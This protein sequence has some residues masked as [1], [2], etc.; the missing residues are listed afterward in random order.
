MNQFY[1]DNV[2]CKGNRIVYHY[3]V[4]GEWVK[5]FCLDEEFFIEY[6]EPIEET[7]E[8]IA[9]IPLLCNILPIAWI[10]DAEIIVK[11]VDKDFFEHVL[12]IK[13]GY[14]DM[15]PRIDFKGKLIPRRIIDN[16]YTPTKDTATFFSGG[17]DAFSTLI[18]HIEERPTLITINGSD[19][20]L[21]NTTGWEKVHN[22]AIT[23]GTKFDCKNLFITSS[24][25]KFLNEGELTN[26]INS[27]SGENWW[28]GFQHGIGLIGHAAPYAYLH[29][30][31]AV[32]IASSF[33]IREKGIVTCASDPSIDNHVHVAS[34]PTIHDG[35]EFTRQMKIHRICEYKE[36]SGKKIPLRVCWESSGGGNCC[37]C[38]KC[39]RTIMAISVENQDPHEYG[40]VFDNSLYHQIEREINRYIIFDTVFLRRYWMEIQETLRLNITRSNKR[41]VLKWVLDTDFEH[42]D[43][44]A[45]V[46]KKKIFRFIRRLHRK[47]HG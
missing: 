45:S 27:R 28:H 29:K 19:I 10:H 36:K 40:F 32:Y 16:T 44:G 23:S 24:F 18:S 5:Y 30:L 13:Q 37:A 39:Y 14:I 11:E 42:M 3:T 7:P 41:E 25:R 9:V 20:Q 46:Y 35:Y 1:L 12:E 17:V 26:S 8:S 34:C 4:S 15:F 2:E 38:E 21:G 22:H 31:K 33:T 47:L 43:V 6:S